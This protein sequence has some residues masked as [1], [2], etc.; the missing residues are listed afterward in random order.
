MPARRSLTAAVSLTAL[1]LVGCGGTTT[2]AEPGGEDT[3]TSATSSATSTP[4]IT[5]SKQPTPDQVVIDV[6]IAGDTIT[7]V[8]SRVQAKPNQEI[9]L[10]IESDR[11]GE[12]HVHSTPEQTPAFER[13]KSTVVLQIDRPGLVEVEDHESGTV[14]V[15]LEIR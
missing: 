15:Q 14:V 4:S 1:L 6:S 11:A 13:G 2:T 9:V 7:P 8:G 3:P 12:L 5:P 10:N